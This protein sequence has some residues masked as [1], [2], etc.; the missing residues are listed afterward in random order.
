MLKIM[1]YNLSLLPLYVIYLI[2]TFNLSML[3]NINTS[4]KWYDMIIDFIFIFYKPLIFVVLSIIGIFT[5]W[6][7]KNQMKIGNELSNSSESIR[8]M[9]YEHL[10]FLATFILPIFT[11]NLETEKDLLI[12]F[13]ILSFM[14][15]VYIKSEMYYLNPVFLIFGW[16]LY[17]IKRDNSEVMALSTFKLDEDYNFIER[18]IDE[19]L[20][21]IQKV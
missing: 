13:V 5:I 1:L 14:G 4:L 8:R 19:N 11:V 3:C 18:K 9:D 21:F 6:Y 20:I 10:T 16:Y 7:F 12:L 17:K 15:F 2:K